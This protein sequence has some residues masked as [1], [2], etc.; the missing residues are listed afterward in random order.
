MSETLSSRTNGR[1]SLPS[2]DFL[3]CS[4]TWGHRVKESDRFI[5]YILH[6]NAIN[7]WFLLSSLIKPFVWKNNNHSVY[8][9]IV[10][11]IILRPGLPQHS[12]LGFSHCA[13]RMWS[14][15]HNLGL[16][17]YT[18]SVKTNTNTSASKYLIHYAL[19]K[20]KQGIGIRII[21]QRSYTLL[22]WL[23]WS[24]ENS[25]YELGSLVFL[26]SWN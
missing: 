21:F 4:F 26:V 14:I 18:Q 16:L 11:L 8:F 15:H 6:N 5:F 3:S 7:S 1:V 10:K 24:M 2:E 20:W 19:K 22:F 9:N 23:C 17:W 13:Q 12:T 25:T